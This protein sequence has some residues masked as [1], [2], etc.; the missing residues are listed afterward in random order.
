MRASMAVMSF[1]DLP[2]GQSRE[3]DLSD[4]THAADVIDLITL[5]GDRELGCFSAMLCDEHHRGVQPVCLNE[6]GPGSSAEVMAQL[7]KLVLPLLAQSGGSILLGRG[8]I[9][10]LRATDEDRRWH[11][12]A[13]ALCREHDVKLLGFHIATPEGVRRLPDPLVA[14]D[15]A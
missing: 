8:R 13:I 7:L 15:V 12:R 10:P 4:H 9:G 2:K 3:L 1:D 6:I 11:E 14:S 5:V